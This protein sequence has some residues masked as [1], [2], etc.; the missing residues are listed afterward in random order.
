MRRN[1]ADAEREDIGAFFFGDGGTFTGGDRSGIVLPRL[2]AFVDPAL[3]DPAVDRQPESNH[4]CPRRQRKDVGCLQRIS[5]DVG[6]PLMQP[7]V[8]E[9]A[10]DLHVD[11][12][13]GQRQAAPLGVDRTQTG[14]GRISQ[15]I[16]QLIERK[17]T[18]HR[19]T[20][21]GLVGRSAGTSLPEA[22][23]PET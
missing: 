12:E 13:I 18:D 2:A 9:Q 3:H 11:I 22:L 23:E 15:H 14:L 10:F 21:L 8:G 20:P 19:R 5:K 1:V 17:G 7:G 16:L 6:K 4:S